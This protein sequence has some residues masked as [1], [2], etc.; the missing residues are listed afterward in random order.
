MRIAAAV[1]T[2]N[3]LHKS[4]ILYK[5]EMLFHTRPRR[6]PPS[7][8][9]APHSAV[10]TPAGLF[11]QKRAGIGRSFSTFAMMNSVMTPV[12]F[13]ALWQVAVG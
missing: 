1:V 5:Y 4:M 9:L 13:G 8:A 6:V 12:S 7:P 2:T 11:P 3:R 10:P